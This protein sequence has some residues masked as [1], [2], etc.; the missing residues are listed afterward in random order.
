[1]L[2]VLITIVIL[3]I[4]LLGLA[5]LQAQA[6]NA[7]AESFSR[8]QAMILA[9]DMADRIASNRLE[10]D[11]TKKGATSVYNTS[12]VYGSSYVNANEVDACTALPS[13]SAS[14]VA[15]RDLCEWD[16]A[17]KGATQ[18]SG[19]G[20]VGGLAGVRGCISR[21]A[22]PIQHY[23]VTVA[24]AG[25]GGLGAAPSDLTCGQGAI[26]PEATRRVISVTVPFAALE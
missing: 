20:K 4:G 22:L 17:L 15:V 1:M 8:A 24:W 11:E 7:E 13:T 25:R 14:E 26:V 9:N 18:T 6:F 10:A 19:G 5:G 16:L 2:E 21:E 23:V 3:G 12:T